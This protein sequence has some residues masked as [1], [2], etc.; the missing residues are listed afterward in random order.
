MKSLKKNKIILYL[1]CFLL[2]GYLFLI[3]RNLKF[4][5]SD[6]NLIFGYIDYQHNWRGLEEFIRFRIPFKDYFYE[7]GWFFLFLQLPAYLFFCRSFLAVLISRHLYLP[8]VGLLL[9]YVVALNVLKKK[10]LILIFLFFFASL[11]HQLRFCFCQTF[12]GRIKPFFFY[13]LPF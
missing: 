7:Y 12:I 8:L 2:L 13:S 1:A 10:H 9:S 3:L 6:I 5:F 4:F 11:W